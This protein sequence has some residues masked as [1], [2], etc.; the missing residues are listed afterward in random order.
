MQSSLLLSPSAFASA[1]PT[2]A[3]DPRKRRRQGLAIDPSN[4]ERG[5]NRE[6]N[7]EE[8][9]RNQICTTIE[10]TAERKQGCRQPPCNPAMTGCAWSLGS[11]LGHEF[12]GRSYAPLGSWPTPL[13][14]LRDSSDGRLL[15]STLRQRISCCRTRPPP[16]HAVDG[17]DH[18]M[19]EKMSEFSARP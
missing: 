2:A 10:R 3:I 4:R 14:P 13:P 15:V 19:M 17:R 16:S 11:L 1:L 5:E 12:L 9:E 18:Q 6:R 8:R 7:R